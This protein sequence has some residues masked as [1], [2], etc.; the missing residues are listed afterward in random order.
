MEVSHVSRRWRSVAVH[1]GGLWTNIFIT[2]RQSAEL[3]S[4]Y[5]KRSSSYPLDVALKPDCRYHNEPFD[6]SPFC[7]IIIPHTEYDNLFC[8][9]LMNSTLCCLI[10]LFSGRT[11]LSCEGWLLTGVNASALRIIIPHQASSLAVH[12]S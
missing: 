3:V 10:I 6:L 9:P 4:L 2:C 12:H 11:F 1:T 5:L 8:I 7:S